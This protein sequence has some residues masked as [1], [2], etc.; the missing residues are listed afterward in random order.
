MKRALGWLISLAVAGCASSSDDRVGGACASSGVEGVAL[1]EDAVSVSNE[2]LGYAPYAIDGCSLV[3]VARAGAADAPGHLVLRDLESGVE[4][5]LS[6]ASESPARPAIS[7]D[8]VAWEA[9]ATGVIRVRV[10]DA[11]DT[12]TGPFDHAREPRVSGRAVV[13]TGFRAPGD[14]SDSDVFLYDVDARS[15]VELTNGPGQ[16]R[17]PDVSSTHVAWSDFSEGPTGVF[18]VDGNDAAD[19][20]LLD[21][22]SGTR[23]TRKKPGKQ[24]F[25]MLG[26]DDKIAYL[27]WNLVHPEPKFSAFELVLGDLVGDGTSDFTASHITTSIYLRPVARGAFVDWIDTSSGIALLRLEVATATSTTVP[28]TV[29][30]LPG[31]LVIGPTASDSVTLLG[32]GTNAADVTLQAFPR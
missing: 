23:T 25:P 6:P 7:G 5:E 14:A 18:D 26:A 13:F 21:R 1:A 2:D 27:D 28:E 31:A 29:A 4:T 11:I 3:Y 24:A 22:R 16:R 17:F 32:T 10:G 12:I 19:I 8:V 15:V 9:R 30:N 20:V